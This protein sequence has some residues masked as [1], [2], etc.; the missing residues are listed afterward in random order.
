MKILRKISF[1]CFWL[2]TTMSYSQNAN[3]NIGAGF[4]QRGLGIYTMS[5]NSGNTKIKGSTYLFP[6]WKTNSIVNMKDGKNYKIPGL[7]YDVKLDKLVSKVG[8]DSLFSF[9]PATIDYA[10]IN[11]RTFKRYLD[12]ELKRNSFYEII[13]TNENLKLL[14]RIN[15][16][17]KKG[18]INP[19]T[20]T[21]ETPDTYVLKNSYFINKGD[22]SKK[23]PSKKREFI[24]IFGGVSG[25]IKEYIK[26]NK[27]SIKK[28]LHLKQIFT[29]YDSL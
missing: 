3:A 10:N 19:M 5:G 12:P 24:E 11:N 4:E 8:I 15:V 17:V 1:L 22:V 28:E 20:K 27:L 7:N 18:H 16:A 13:V 21:Q 2:M 29:Y 14:K 6:D 25:N 23:V 26:Q 9:N